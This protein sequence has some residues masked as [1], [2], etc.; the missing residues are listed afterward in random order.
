MKI[1]YIFNHHYGLMD[2]IKGM[3]TL[4][5]LCHIKN[6][7]FYYNT[8]KLNINIKFNRYLNSKYLNDATNICSKSYICNDS[9]DRFLTDLYYNDIN[10]DFLFIESNIDP[11]YCYKTI[12]NE[13]VI[14]NF[15]NL[16]SKN[17]LNFDFL[18]QNN[19]N[20]IP[21]KNITLHFRFGDN[22][23]KDGNYTIDYNFIEKG[24]KSLIKVNDQN[25]NDKNILLVGDNKE[26]IKLIINKTNETLQKKI[27]FNENNNPKHFSK[28]VTEEE[29]D[30][31]FSDVYNILQS[32][33]IFFCGLGPGSGFAFYI[34]LMG[35][36]EY[37]RI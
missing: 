21:E 8:S 4:F 32:E 15:I 1:C 12:L 5:L 27:I 29:L 23:L 33:Q 24:L 36:I 19:I 22:Y 20:I 7:S 6:Y 34:S 30:F 11:L 2:N 37:N 28:I 13:I 10:N 26:M 16:Q 31:L 25:I 3:I 18:N 14:K 35:N 17:L 9:I